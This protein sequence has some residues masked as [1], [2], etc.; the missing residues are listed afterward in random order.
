MDPYIE[1]S[2]NGMSFHSV[3]IAA[4]WEALN[5][6]LP[7][8]YVA[9][10]DQRTHLVD[11]SEEDVRIILPDIAATG[12]GAAGPA[13]Q[14]QSGGVAT[15]EPEAIPLPVYEERR[16]R[17]IEIHTEPEHQ[18]VTVIEV[19]SSTN[20]SH[21]GFA[22]YTSKRR[23]ILRQQVHLLEID[24]FLQGKRLPLAEPLPKGDYY[25][26]LSRANERPMCEV[27]LWGLR[28]ALPI[29][30]VPLKA[31]DGDIPLK[32]DELF[33]L[34]YDRGRY[35]QLLGYDRPA[36]LPVSEADRG[37]AGEIS[38]TAR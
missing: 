28:H 4:C 27:Y 13:G 21:E 33:T 24:L 3:F 15:L 26:L 37:W 8:H 20:K 9:S 38:A 36:T 32:L 30:P 6:T 2:G 1:A 11:V 18:L 22:E 7:T 34:T 19:L 10:V 12:G 35:G 5:A 23:A 17:R 29:L 16:E 31:P 14:R 25:A